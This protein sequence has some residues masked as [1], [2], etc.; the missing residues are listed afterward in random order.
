M[1]AKKDYRV[2]GVAGGKGNG[3]GEGGKGEG[4]DICRKAY[5]KEDV[6]HTARHSS[7]GSATDMSRAPVLDSNAFSHTVL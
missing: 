5:L 2:D 7:K 6:R 3:G 1:P 4:D